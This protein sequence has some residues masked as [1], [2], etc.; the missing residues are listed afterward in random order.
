MDE[1]N[2]NNSNID[3]SKLIADGTKMLWRKVPI[4]VK[5]WIIGGAAVVLFL[6]III[7]AFSGGSS[8]QVGDYA[9]EV[10]AS[11]SVE[12]DFEEFWTELCDEG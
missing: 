11:G 1:N 7:A 5:L 3:A 8:Y 2:N 12:E 6:I 10:T 9:N 4:T